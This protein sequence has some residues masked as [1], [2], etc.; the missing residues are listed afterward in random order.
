MPN[1]LMGLYSGTIVKREDPDNGDPD[2]E[3]LGRVK[4]EIPGLISESAWAWPRHFG[5]AEKWGKNAVPPLGAEV[6][7][8]FVN[9]MVDNPVWEPAHHGQNQAFP[10]FDHPDMIV[11]GTASFRLVHDPREGQ[12]YAALKAIKEV[13]G[14]EET[15]IEIRFDIENNMLSIHGETGVLVSTIGQLNMTTNHGGDVEIQGRKV[16]KANRTI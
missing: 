5:G 2:G 10:E 1:E 9:G 11:M 6:N 3:M 12:R 16:L 7:V 13:D 14:N 8:Q 15:L 4:V